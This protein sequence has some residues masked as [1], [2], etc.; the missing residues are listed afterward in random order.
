MKRGACTMWTGSTPKLCDTFLGG[1]GCGLRLLLS[2]RLGFSS[3]LMLYLEGNR[4]GVY[5]VGLGCQGNRISKHG[6]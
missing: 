1:L 2:F 5:L 3:E 6:E 4:I